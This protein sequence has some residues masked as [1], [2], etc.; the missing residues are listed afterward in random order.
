MRRYL[1]KFQNPSGPLPGGNSYKFTNSGYDFTK[2]KLPQSPVGK[3]TPSPTFGAQITKE[4]MFSFKMPSSEDIVSGAVSAFNQGNTKASVT[5]PETDPGTET[6]ADKAAERA[7]RREQR[8]EN[9]SFANPLGMSEQGLN[10]MGGIAQGVNAAAYIANTLVDSKAV[11]S[12]AQGQ[13]AIGNAL[14]QSGNPYL[15]AAGA[16]YNALSVIGEATGLNSST[17]NAEQASA[18]GIS[19]GQ[20]FLNN[21]GSYVP[22]LGAAGTKAMDALEMTDETRSLTSAFAGSVGDISTAGTLGGGRYLAGGNKVNQLIAEAN[23]N[24]RI[25]TDMS[26]TN[27]LRKQSDY[28]SDIAQ[29]NLNRYAGNNY[30]NNRIGKEGMKLMPIEEVR[31]LLNA[32]KV[33]MLVKGVQSFQNGGVIGIDTNV[34]PEG[35][36]HAHLNHLNEENPELDVTRKGIPVVVKEADGTISQIAEV[37][38]EEIILTKTLTDQLEALYKIGDDVSMIEAGKLLATELV[39]NTI[40]NGAEKD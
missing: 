21:L 39:T 18:A 36:L 15:M 40:D 6:V 38:C 34:I 35:K 8:K 17:L 13:Q 5:P 26:K 10:T 20:K 1:P 33:D 22:M 3:K 19:K 23:R 4:N 7:A 14:M 9:R 30:L 24:N 37:E 28:G 31:S 16:A 27:S 11:N 25:L 32:R 2:M 29:Q 12:N